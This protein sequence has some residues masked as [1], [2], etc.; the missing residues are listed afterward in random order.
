MSEERPLSAGEKWDWAAIIFSILALWPKFILKLP[1]PN[2]IWEMLVYLAG[3]LMIIVLI[4]K[5]G[6]IRALTEKDLTDDTCF[7]K[8]PGAEDAE[9]L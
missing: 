5:T 8:P 7:P 4:R 6:R 2:R 9:Q 1:D 3:A